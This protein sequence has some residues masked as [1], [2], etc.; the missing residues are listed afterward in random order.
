MFRSIAGMFSGNVAVA[1]SM[2]SEITDSTNQGTGGSFFHFELWDQSRG[3]SLQVSAST[4]VKAMILEVTH[5][6]L[7]RC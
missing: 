2:L 6:Y 3:E 5:T 1:S 4:T 7:V